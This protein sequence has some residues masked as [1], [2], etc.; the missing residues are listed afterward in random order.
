MG[1][2]LRYGL[3]IPIGEPDAGVAKVRRERRKLARD[4]DAGLV[5][6]DEPPRGEGVP[7]MPRAA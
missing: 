6:L 7:L 3:D 5:P 1:E 4:V 2:Q